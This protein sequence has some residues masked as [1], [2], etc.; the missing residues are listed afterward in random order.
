MRTKVIFIK[1]NARNKV[2][3]LEQNKGVS[4]SYESTRLNM[5]RVNRLLSQRS[6]T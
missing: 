6:I 1:R 4:V 3:H 5:N 2:M